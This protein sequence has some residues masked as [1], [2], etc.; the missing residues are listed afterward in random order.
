MQ[1]QLLHEVSVGRLRRSR[2]GYGV[3]ERDVVLLEG[4]GGV[5]EAS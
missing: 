1:L 5:V 2:F 3:V 4:K